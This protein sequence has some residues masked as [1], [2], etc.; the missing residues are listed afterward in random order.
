ME[1][2]PGGWVVDDEEAEADEE[3]W[4]E[5]FGVERVAD[6]KAGETEA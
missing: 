6:D 5:E 2:H 4:Y 1:E 3:A